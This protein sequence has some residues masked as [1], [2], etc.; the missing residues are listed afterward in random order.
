MWGKDGDR[1]CIWPPKGKMWSTEKSNGYYYNELPFVIYACFVL[2]NY[3][4]EHGEKIN[5]MKLSTAIS[6]ERDY[7]PMA[8]CNNLRTDCNELEGKRVRREVA[9]F[10][11]P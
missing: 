11:H 5:E 4:E 3:C 2:H 7:Q 1:M 8:I 10:L 6:F 9:K